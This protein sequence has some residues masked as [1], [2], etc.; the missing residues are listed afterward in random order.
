MS[1]VPGGAARGA[2]TG[3]F[4]VDRRRVQPLNMIPL[5]ALKARCALE[6]FS[7]KRTWARRSKILQC[8]GLKPFPLGSDER[9]GSGAGRRNG[10][11]LFFAPRLKT[12]F[13]GIHDA[14]VAKGALSADSSR[15]ASAGLSI[16]P[17]GL[18]P[19]DRHGPIRCGVGRRDLW[20]PFGGANKWAR[21]R[22]LRRP[23]THG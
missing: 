11:G 12:M 16:P 23:T 14:L 20:R 22:R 13:H 2:A 19:A 1:G 10:N 6:H 5:L 15:S 17:P 21:R 4:A 3:G 7:P 18:S 9:S 8:V